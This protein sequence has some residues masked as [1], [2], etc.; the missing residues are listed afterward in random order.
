[1]N[2]SVDQQA[3]EKGAVDPRRIDGRRLV[4]QQH[5]NNGGDE[6]RGQSGERAIGE[7]IFAERRERE[8]PIAHGEWN[9]DGG[10]N[11]TTNEVVPYM[12]RPIHT[13]DTLDKRTRSATT[14]GW[15]SALGVSSVMSASLRK[16]DIAAADI[17]PALSYQ[18]HAQDRIFGIGE[19]A[20][21]RAQRAP[22]IFGLAA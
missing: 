1:M 14:R 12:L 15:P 7:V 2:E 20:K 11:D 22:E 4:A 18:S 16:A 9:G 8:H 6:R 17:N 19:I 10:G 13:G 21:P 5:A 3:E